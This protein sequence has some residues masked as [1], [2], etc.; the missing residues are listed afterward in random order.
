MRSFQSQPSASEAM[1][2]A[3]PDLPPSV[4]AA[5]WRADQLG[6]SLRRVLPSG[7]AELDAQLPGGGWPCQAVT[8]LLAAQFALFEWR[9][10]APAFRAVCASGK[11]LA[12]VG[13]PKAPH[14]PGLRQAGIDEQHL[15]W[16]DVPVDAP[17]QALW[18][19]EQL[20][21]SNA[22][23]AILG[24]L[25]HVR[26]EQVRR[27][28]ILAT[29]AD[30][31]VFL[32]RPE[33]A[34]LESSA[35]PL[36]LHARVGLDWALQIDILKRQGPLMGRSLWLP[37]VPDGLVPLLT[38]RLMQPSLLTSRGARDVVVRT[39]PALRQQQPIPH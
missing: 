12:L 34:A 35:A 20:I 19:L 3:R 2:A 9:L 17:K 13:P 27:L 11:V 31:P 6:S 25:P 5:L 26:P 18:A 7:F 22:C 8:E 30:A 16:V 14:L 28:H 33:R 4:A 1:D 38:P 23:G 39:A 37:S 29:A 10:L 21:R 15:V 32:C 36:R 24:W